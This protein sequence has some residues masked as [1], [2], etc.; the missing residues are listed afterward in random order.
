MQRH[1]NSF[2]E[3]ADEASISRVYGGIHYMVSVNEGANTGR[4]V[5]EFVIKKV[6]K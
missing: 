3:A 5:G 1:F 6:L 2:V 4:K